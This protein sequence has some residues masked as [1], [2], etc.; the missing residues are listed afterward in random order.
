MKKNKIVMLQL[1][2]ALG[3]TLGATA[4]QAVDCNAA[5]KSATELFTAK[6]SKNDA[7]YASAKKAMLAQPDEKHI[8]S[9]L[10]RAVDDGLYASPEAMEKAAVR[11]CSRK[12]ASN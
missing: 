11:Y 2:L 5:A 3:L 7:A 4:V 12:L 10:V 6:A 8:Y 9:M 1:A